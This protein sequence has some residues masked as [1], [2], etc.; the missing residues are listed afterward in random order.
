MTLYVQVAAQEGSER[1]MVGESV[2]LD[3]AI[4]MDR[5]I[6]T[7]LLDGKGVEGVPDYDLLLVGN[8]H[9]LHELRNQL[10]RLLG[11]EVRR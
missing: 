8:V 1:Q 11:P 10:T 9:Q 7:P 2:R 5:K 6:L 4:V 3:N